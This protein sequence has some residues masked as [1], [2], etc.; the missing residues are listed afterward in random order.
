MYE[1]SVLKNK[2]KQNQNQPKNKT[3]APSFPNLVAQ[4]DKGSKGLE[5]AK[6]SKALSKAPLNTEL[7]K[8]LSAN[9]NSVLPKI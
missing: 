3:K 7:G 2:I 9:T 8:H 5:E 4:H 6:T 1:S